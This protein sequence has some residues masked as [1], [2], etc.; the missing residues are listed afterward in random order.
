MGLEV[1]SEFLEKAPILKAAA[2]TAGYQLLFF[3][4]TVLLRFDKLTDFAG[5]SNFTVLALW[6][7]FGFSSFQARQR[8]LTSMVILWSA[9]LALYLGYRILFVFG[10][11]NRLDEFRNSASK[12]LFFWSFQ[13]TWAFVVCLPILLVNIYG[14]S[15]PLSRLDYFGCCFFVIGFLCESIADF[16]KLYFKKRNADHWCDIGLWKYSR[17]P[18]YFGELLMWHSLYLISWRGLSLYH[19]LIAISSPLLLLGYCFGKYGAILEYQWYKK[20]TSL[21]IPLPPSLTERINHWFSQ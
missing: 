7:Y 17:H 2:I 21:L 8:L 4:P 15:I 9:R 18:N 1:V 10:K 14:K 13:G 12:L 3:V 20:R 11:D 6:S 5:A 19:R 16:Q